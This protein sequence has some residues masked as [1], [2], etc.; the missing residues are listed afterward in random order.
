MN[1]ATAERLLAINREFYNH[2]GDSFSA[3]RQR[4]QPGVKK[5]SKQLKKMIRF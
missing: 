5:Y 4:L 1:L 3:T 2:F